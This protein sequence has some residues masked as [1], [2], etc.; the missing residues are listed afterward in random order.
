MFEQDQYYSMSTNTNRVASLETELTA[1]I[2]TSYN[3]ASYS[4]PVQMS[5]VNKS[6]WDIA[7]RSLEVA[8]HQEELRQA[9][10]SLTNTLQVER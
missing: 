5:Q 4:N 8:F 7:Q 6:L 3:Y 2:E 9:V 10:V 1:L